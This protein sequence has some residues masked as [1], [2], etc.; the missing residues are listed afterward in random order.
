MDA[1]YKGVRTARFVDR[2]NRFVV[3]MEMDGKTVTAH[4]PNPGRMGELL[5]RGTLLYAAPHQRAGAKTA[6]R[7]VG[8]EREGEV[9]LLD[10]SRCNDV[11]ARLIDS[12]CIPG[13]EGCHVVRREVTMGDSRFDLLLT[14]G[15]ETFPVEV[16]SCTL[17]GKQGAMFPDAVTA[18]GRKH[19]IHLGKM[20]KEGR[21]AGLL[22]LVHW[23][24]AD[25]FL[26]D[27]HTDP[28][29]AA[30]F[31]EYAPFIDWKAAAVKWTADF[32]LPQSVRLLSYPEEVLAKEMGNRGDYLA[33]LYLPED[34]DIV[35]GRKGLTHFPKGYYVYTGSAKRN[36]D[37][38]MAHHRRLRKRKHW[39]MDYLRAEAE[40]VG[41][42]PVRTSFDLEH[43]LAQAVS[44]IA[45]WTIPGFGCTDCACPS[46]LFGMKENP[47]HSRAFR[48]VEE[49]FRMNRMD[50][51]IEKERPAAF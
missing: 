43:D 8:V 3:H 28:D 7:I 31:H 23:D 6:W 49:D 9:I 50:E 37:Q 46:H 33:V 11:A 15:K 35:I 51:L 38:R 41:I 48:K 20:G 12:G 27:Y 40:W 13:W 22:I 47:L 30:A 45:D 14:D 32:T 1:L 19:L 5:Y 17:F 24:R 18:R 25:W 16:K 42:L 26:P 44:A 36:L 29:F 21:R 34:K 39:H 4:M 2:P 10:T